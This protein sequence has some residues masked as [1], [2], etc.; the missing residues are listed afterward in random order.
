MCLRTIRKVNDEEIQH[1]INEEAES[2]L[3]AAYVHGLRGIVGQQVQHNGAG[4]EVSCDGRR[5]GETQ[6]ANR[7]SQEDIFR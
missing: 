1:I 3:L 7:K 5:R 6:A 2:R 4:S